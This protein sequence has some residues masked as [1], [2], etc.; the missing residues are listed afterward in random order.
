M[1]CVERCLRAIGFDRPDRMPV[2]P[3][4][5]VWTLYHYGSTSEACME[6]GFL[7]AE[8]QIR[9]QREFGWDGVFVATDSTALA[10]SLGTP[11][12]MTE[13]GVVPGSRGL[14][15]S[16]RAARDLRFPDP[17]E[18]RLN[19][20]IKATEI[21]V[22]EIGS[23]VLVIARAD[24]APFSL[25]CQLC[26]MQE[27][28]TALG[29]RE[30][31]EDIRKLLQKSTE[32]VWSFASLLLDAGA[33]VVTIGDALA[34]GSVI[35]PAMFDEYAF[36]YQKEIAGR[37]HKRGGKLSIHVCGQTTAVMKRLAETGADVVEFD[38][39]TDFAEA[40][41]VSRDK[42]CLLGNVDTSEVLTFGTPERV[43]E[44]CRKR[45]EA[46]KPESG[47]I[48]SSG[49]ALSPNTSAENVRAMVGAAREYGV[50]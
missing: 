25:A 49:C 2:I 38:A 8:L 12:E 21:L 42:V 13:T 18:T 32:Y 4:A 35:S 10:H 29:T 40:W 5:H 19:E 11:V 34:S 26:G 48:L 37:V 17:R 47:Y 36:P 46:V 9:A 30:H 28:M 31:P 15:E 33:H 50:Y 22:R 39:P 23:E 27:F 20:W 43:A 7:Y 41:K 1:T 24:Q 14:F 16:I 3:Q 45:I 6:D 44:E